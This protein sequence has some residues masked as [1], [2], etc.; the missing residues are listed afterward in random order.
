MT[1][2][3]K[4][5]VRGTVQGVGFR[6]YVY[7]LAKRGGLRGQVLNN[8]SGVVIDLEGEHEAIDHFV[9]ELRKTPPALSNIESVLRQDGIVDVPF[10]DFHI[11][12]S[13]SNGSARLPIAPDTAVCDECLVEMFDP[14]DR[15]YRYPFIN[16]TNCG[17]RFTIVESV[18]YDRERTTMSDFSMC[19]ACRAEY[20]DP[21]DRR[22]H[23]EPIACD[24][25]GPHLFLFRA[26]VA[27]GFPESGN[28]PHHS[29]R[30]LQPPADGGSCALIRAVRR[31]IDD[32][33]IVAVKSLG[34]YHLVCDATNADA[35][36]RLR[37]RKVR[38]EKPFA[39]MAGS[40]EVIEKYCE[41]SDTENEILK[42]R[43]RPIVL[44]SKKAASLPDEVAPG[45]STFG[46]MLPYTPL[47][48]LLL[49]DRDTPLVMTSGNISDEPI[50]YN[51]ADAAERLNHIA[52]FFL[53]NDR[54]INIR[55]DD[56]I[57]RVNKSKIQNP[58]SKIV[59]RRSRGYAPAPIHTSFDFGRQ[60]LAC[61]AELKNTFCIGRG[62]HAFVSHHIGDL[63]NLETLRS[64]TDGIEHFKKL[65][66]LEPECDRVRSPPGISFD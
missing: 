4:I 24:S 11:L 10:K 60:I 46:F 59:I 14:G 41:V 37:Q 49:E 25:C 21:L 16:C 63:E 20:E 45:V 33:R 12:P 50:A 53:T 35:V 62:N 64:F 13:R 61:G 47:H 3:T 32:G 28:E 29:Y 55:I 40:V 43:E 52:D 58:K 27:G 57:V 38:E 7:S 9:T 15:R 26:A 18:P 23:A 31:L 1:T 30:Q 6:P 51:D 39:L 54:R 44:L 36:M 65:F 34:G 66:D 22:Y 5:L 17:P 42:S 48:Y 8:E 19:A 56:S 2:R